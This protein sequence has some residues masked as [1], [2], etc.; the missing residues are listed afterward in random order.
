M[1]V[2]LDCGDDDF[3]RLI[4]IP[5]DFAIVCENGW[6]IIHL[7]ASQVAVDLGDDIAQSFLMKLS[8]KTNV[9]SLINEKDEYGGGKT[10]LHWAAKKNRRSVI[11]TLFELG[12][13]LNVKDNNNQLPDDQDECDDETKAL[14]QRLR[15]W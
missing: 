15:Q 8:K 9:E 6:N 7:I 4:N 10:P 3:D 1:N 12:G 14:I 2:A 5:Q 11:Q 13:D